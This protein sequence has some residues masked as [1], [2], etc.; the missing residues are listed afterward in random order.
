MITLTAT[1]RLAPNAA[2]QRPSG[3]S[4]SPPHQGVLE[5][6]PG[7]GLRRKASSAVEARLSVCFFS[8]RMSHRVPNWDHAVD[9]DCY[10]T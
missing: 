3:V 8:G 5:A 9:L 6:E 10:R 2:L 1:C 4:R 7:V